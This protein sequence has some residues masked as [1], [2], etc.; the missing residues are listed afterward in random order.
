MAPHSSA[1][2]WAKE[3]Q[4][5]SSRGTSSDDGL[6]HQREELAHAGVEQERLLVADEEL[7]E[8]EPAGGATSGD[9]GGEAED[10][11]GDLVD[12]GVHRHGLSSGRRPVRALATHD[13]TIRLR[14]IGRTPTATPIS[15]ARRV[16]R[17]SRTA[18]A[19]ASA[20]LRTPSLVRTRPTWCSAVLGEMNRRS[21]ISALVRPVAHEVEHLLLAAGQAGGQ[22]AGLLGASRPVSPERPQQRRR[23]V[24]GTGVGAEPLEAASAARASTMARRRVAGVG[25]DL[26]QLEAHAARA[27]TVARRRR[28]GAWPTSNGREAAGWSPAAAQHAAVGERGVGARAT[29]RSTVG[30]QRGQLVGRRA[31]PRRGRRGAARPRRAAPSSGAGPERVAD[32][33]RRSPRRSTAAARSSSPRQQVHPGE[34]GAAGDP[35]LEGR[36][37]LG[38]LL[39][40]A[41]LDP[42]A[43]QVGDGQRPVGEA[44]RR[45]GRAPRSSAPRPP[46]TARRRTAP[47]R[48]PPGSGCAARAADRRARRRRRRRCR[49]TPRPGDIAG[50]VAGRQHRA[51]ADAGG[52]RAPTSPAEIA[53]IA[54]SRRAKPSLARPCDTRRQAAVGQRLR[55]EVGS[56]NSRAM[57]GRGRRSASRSSTS[58]RSQAM[59]ASSRYPTRRTARRVRAAAGPAPPTPA[60]RPGGPASPT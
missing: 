46:A 25:E 31:R 29:A 15:L 22:L 58:W 5:R 38:R 9:Q 47:T 55:L 24:S 4:R 41:L 59:N 34:R 30:G 43:G 1:S 12:G 3:I 53:A 39:E 2:T 7:V 16:G 40:P 50:P 44:A 33:A 51:E 32:A 21:A 26:G 17:G 13:G 28:G 52:H 57:R 42:Q 11:G 14:D 10:V 18:S 6:G 27:G 60:P 23:P 48:R 19:A 37:Q 56:P 35:V 49:S 36:E 20:R 54:A 8:G 45:P